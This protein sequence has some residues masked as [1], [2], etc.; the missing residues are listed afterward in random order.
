MEKALQLYISSLRTNQEKVTRDDN[1]VTKVITVQSPSQGLRFN[2][3]AFD[4][5][6]HSWSGFSVSSLPDSD[7]A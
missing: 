3:H 7:F 4:S 5:Q 2:S 1:F 6:L